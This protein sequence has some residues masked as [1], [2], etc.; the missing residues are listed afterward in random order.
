VTAKHALSVAG[1]AAFAV[2]IV[3]AAASCAD[4][5]ADARIGLT[6]PSATQFAPVGNLLD[7]RCGSLDCHGNARRNLVIY[8]CEGLRL[9]PADD[10]GPLLTPG[11]R[12][13][14]GTDTTG[15]ATQPGTELYATYRSLVG[16]EPTVMSEVVT[17]GGAHPELL[18]FIRKARGWDAHKGGQIWDAGD[19][20]DDCA[21]SWLTGTTDTTA[22]STALTTTP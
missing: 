14:G 12:S 2:A 17:G 1:A 4:V 10:A 21:T 22:C 5:P 9:E 20:S 19:T 3:G 6:E 15:P 13:S 7:H 8:G 18:T 11:C 16:L